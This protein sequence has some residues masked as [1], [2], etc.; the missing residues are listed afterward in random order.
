MR[1]V[2]VFCFLFIG[3]LVFSQDRNMVILLDKNQKERV[4][5]EEFN[6]THQLIATLEQKNSIVIAHQSL[7][8]NY[9]QRRA[10]FAKNKTQGIF[11]DIQNLYQDA[12][13]A[14]QLQSLQQVNANLNTRWY[15]KRYPHLAKLSVDAM[16]QLQFNF[17]CYQHPL[18]MSYWNI[19]KVG[20]EFVVFAPRA[21]GKIDVAQYVNR[22]VTIDRLVGDVMNRLNSRWYLYAS[23]HGTLAEESMPGIIAGMSVERFEIFLQTLKKHNVALFVYASCYA[24][25]VHSVEPYKGMSFD[26]PI[27]VFSLTDAST[28][29][30]GNPAGVKL[31]P[32]S[33][34]HALVRE[35]FKQGLKDVFMVQI[36]E[37]VHVVNGN[38]IDVAALRKLSPFYYCQSGRCDIE[39]A[40]NIPLVRYPGKVYFSLLTNR[41]IKNMVHIIDRF[42]DLATADKLMLVYAKLMKKI[43]TNDSHVAPLISMLPGRHTHKIQKLEAHAI[44]FK[45]LMKQMFFGIDDAHL[46]KTFLVDSVTCQ[47]D[48][49]ADKPVET[50]Q[51]VMVLHEHMFMPESMAQAQ[52]LVFA[53]LETKPYVIEF[54]NNDIH[55]V[56]VLSS[57][58]H[59]TIKQLQGYLKKSLQIGR[60]RERFELELDRYVK[61]KKLH[62]RLIDECKR[63]SICF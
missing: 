29:V 62:D 16:K 42:D 49:K 51:N 38:E 4:N 28:Y 21:W 24:G 15:R 6:V 54:W 58:D 19:T 30:F 41:K 44:G 20:N 12:N 31:P 33:S 27:I 8:K 5:S 17:F 11:K 63:K 36:N 52:S 10:L 45:D 14:L 32:Y 53:E 26:F 22:H 39:R 48:F 59:A 60:D 23:G 35:D 13:Q 47:N 56:K 34:H 25:G 43:T 40:E 3:S 61:S 18:A 1:K 37:M 9:Q 46:Q 55:D 50:F 7:L 2:L 57:E